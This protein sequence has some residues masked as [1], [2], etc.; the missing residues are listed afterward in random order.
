MFLVIAYDIADDK[1]RLKM[2]KE[3]ERWGQRTQFSVF[4]CDLNELEERQMLVRL[5][6]ICRES[7]AL[8]IYRICETCLKKGDVIGG[9]EFAS[10]KDFYQI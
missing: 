10:D 9:K 2:A 5:K 6:E 7:D 3:L 4:E 8:R 1:R